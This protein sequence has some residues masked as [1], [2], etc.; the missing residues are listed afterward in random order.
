ML[1]VA[2][3]PYF[4]GNERKALA[5]LTSDALL[6]VSAGGILNLVAMQNGER[7]SIDAWAGDMHPAWAR[8]IAAVFPTN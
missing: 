5:Y 8:A 6:P 7:R 1:A 2:S 3:H 4:Q